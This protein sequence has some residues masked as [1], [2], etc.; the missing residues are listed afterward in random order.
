VFDDGRGVTHV[1]NA[2]FA[3]GEAG[4]GQ[5]RWMATGSVASW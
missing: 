4:Y 2:V 3:D 1:G 5:T